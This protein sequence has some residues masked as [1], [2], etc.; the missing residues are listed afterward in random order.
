MV[1]EAR[2]TRSPAMSR[3]EE[4]CRLVA[5]QA[6]ARWLMA[7]TF[8]SPVLPDVVIRYA[9]CPRTTDKS[10]GAFEIRTTQY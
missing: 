8:G 1:I 5:K 2:I 3:N 6:K 4:H 10:R 7:M 9:V